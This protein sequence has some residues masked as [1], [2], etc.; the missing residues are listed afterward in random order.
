MTS[1]IT[2]Q[3]LSPGAEAT[4]KHQNV[5][6]KSFG[7]KDTFKE[8]GPDPQTFACKEHAIEVKAQEKFLDPQYFFS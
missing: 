5:S 8:C 4:P 6:L 2:A 7:Q 1:S 3:I